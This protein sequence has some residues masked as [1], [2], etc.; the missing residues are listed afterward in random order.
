[1]NVLIVVENFL[2]CILFICL[3][4]YFACVLEFVWITGSWL[5]YSQ[6]QPSLWKV[7][8][9]FELACP[10]YPFVGLIAPIFNNCDLVFGR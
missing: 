8:S 9:L 7:L 6:C 2:F 1:M 4:F 3:I 10:L 5:G